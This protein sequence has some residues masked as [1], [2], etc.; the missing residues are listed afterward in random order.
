MRR[1]WDICK[2]KVRYIWLWLW[3]KDVVIFL[4]FIGLS[5]IFWFGRAMSSPRDMKLAVGVNFLSRRIHYGFRRGT[6]AYFIY[7]VFL[8]PDFLK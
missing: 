8:R 3:R 4:L 5:S 2:K 7:K 1:Y 6:V